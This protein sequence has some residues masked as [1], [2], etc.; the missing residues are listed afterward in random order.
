M[1]NRNLAGDSG[2]SPIIS[3]RL[4]RE[5]VEAIDRVV[6]DRAVAAG[7]GHEITRSSVLRDALIAT[8]M[9]PE[10]L[11]KPAPSKDQMVSVT[12]RCSPELARLFYSAAT[13]WQ[14]DIGPPPVP[15]TPRSEVSVR[16]RSRRTSEA[17]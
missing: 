4:P 16:T 2:Y 9:P 17:A 7:P 10:A 13:A 14:P 1:A 15:P 8:F 5:T 12:F 3:L 6:F 11:R